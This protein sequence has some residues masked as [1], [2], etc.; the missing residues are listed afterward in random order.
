VARITIVPSDSLIIIDGEVANN[1]NFSGLDPAITAIQWYGA[2]G[3]IEYAKDPIT[4][5]GLPNQDITS[6]APYNSYV[7]QAQ[8][9]IFAQ[10][11]PVDYWVNTEAGIQY[12][13]LPYGFGAL[14]RVSDVGW[15]QPSGTTT[16]V[17]PTPD[18]GQTLY[19][20]SGQWV[21]SYVD[22]TQ[23][24]SSNKQALITA[25]SVSAA[26][27]M[28]EQSSSYS[29][30]QLVQS[31]DPTL[32]PCAYI[33]SLTLGDYQTYLDGEVS[34]TVAQINA[35]TDN[36]TLYNLNPAIDPIP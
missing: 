11:N 20:Y 12:E 27:A 18:A 15:P 14:I 29:T 21:P 16:S 5:A 17:P 23:S 32:L 28:S 34:A 22:P 9:I 31:A 8:Q 30:L 13:G 4:S 10:N 2:V 26:A 19:W 36:A 7:T 35:A 25:C 3:Q 33:D 1:I 6:L 24:L